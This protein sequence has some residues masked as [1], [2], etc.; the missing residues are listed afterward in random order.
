MFKE[1]IVFFCQQTQQVNT[2]RHQNAESDF[3]SG[4]T[5]SYHCSLK[6]ETSVM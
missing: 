4:G 5:F 6:A 3:K 1:I 2:F